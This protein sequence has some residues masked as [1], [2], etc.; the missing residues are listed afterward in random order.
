MAPYRDPHP[1]HR[2]HGLQIQTDLDRYGADTG[3]VEQVNDHGTWIG[4]DHRGRKI[5][6][7]GGCIL[8]RAANGTETLL[9][10]FNADT[11]R[12]LVAPEWARTW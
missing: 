7:R 12:E 10:E 5:V 8:E 2:P 3:F 9:K 11:K 4:T 6:A 1:Q